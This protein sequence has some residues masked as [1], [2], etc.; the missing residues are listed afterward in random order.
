MHGFQNP[1]LQKLN[2]FDSMHGKEFIQCLHINENH[3]ITVSTVGCPP[4]TIKVYDTMHGT[5]STASKVIVAD[6]MHVNDKYITVEYVNVQR[7]KGSS[8]C[9]P[10]AIAI[11]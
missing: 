10:L 3:W 11:A 8:S 7:Q 4:A 2:T 6:M 5:L 1:L 9:G